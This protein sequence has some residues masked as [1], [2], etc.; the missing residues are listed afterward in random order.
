[1]TA[2][3]IVTALLGRSP[4]FLDE[5]HG[6]FSVGGDADADFASYQSA[7]VLTSVVLF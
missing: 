5:T 1:M 2:E 4:V 7:Q 6:V 3:G